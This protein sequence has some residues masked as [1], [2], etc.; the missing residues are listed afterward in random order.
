MTLSPTVNTDTQSIDLVCERFEPHA[1]RLVAPR[2]SLCVR[3]QNIQLPDDCPSRSSVDFNVR[4][5]IWLFD[6]F[7]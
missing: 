2:D 3:P 5:A 4:S 1:S 7:T 6:L